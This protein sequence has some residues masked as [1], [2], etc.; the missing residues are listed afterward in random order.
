LRPGCR[1]ILVSGGP[2]RVLSH[3]HGPW[4]R[5]LARPF[6]LDELVRTVEEA[7]SEGVPGSGI[8]SGSE[9]SPVRIG[10]EE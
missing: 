4:I 1:V 7:L 2:S 5:H 8:D 6:N 10:R 9:G 3:P